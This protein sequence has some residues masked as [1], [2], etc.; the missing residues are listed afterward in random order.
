MSSPTKTKTNQ[1]FVWGNSLLNK[2][3]GRSRRQQKREASKKRRAALKR[4]Q[5]L[6][7]D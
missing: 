3:P 6:E 1:L 2:L 5:E 7:R 4:E